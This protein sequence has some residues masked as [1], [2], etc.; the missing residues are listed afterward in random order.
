MIH[1]F[2]IIVPVFQDERGSEYDLQPLFSVLV[3]MLIFDSVSLLVKPSETWLSAST[4]GGKV[5]GSISAIDE[6]AGDTV[7]MGR[8]RT[9]LRVGG[10]SWT[11]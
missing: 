3:L 1:L 5:G 4:T 9:T 11:D 6:D 10:D 7:G 2:Y 8:G